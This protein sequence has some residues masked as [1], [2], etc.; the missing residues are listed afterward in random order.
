M[1]NRMLLRFSNGEREWRYGA[2]DPPQPGDTV[3]SHG[4]AWRIDAVEPYGEG[5]WL[6]T[7]SPAE[8][9]ADEMIGEAGDTA[10]AVDLP[11]EESDGRE[12][13]G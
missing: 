7:L 3:T 12:S 2:D 10:E 11:Q 5:A 8:P 4:G 6:V 13:D 1:P 9:H